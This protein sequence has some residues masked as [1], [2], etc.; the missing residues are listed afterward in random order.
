MPLPPPSD[1]SKTKICKCFKY[2]AG[3]A[4][5]TP[6]Q[7]RYHA[8]QVAPS[9]TTDKDAGFSICV[10]SGSRAPDTTPQQDG[11]DNYGNNFLDVD[12]D[13]D[14]DIL[15][16]LDLPQEH[17]HSPSAPPI[18]P[19]TPVQPLNYDAFPRASLGNLALLQDMIANI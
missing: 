12:Q 11:L 7:L 8:N 5:V 18:H 10:A 13:F 16:Y 4:W 14:M 15:D 1:P 9:V 3:G 2:C 6:R 17:R 19:I